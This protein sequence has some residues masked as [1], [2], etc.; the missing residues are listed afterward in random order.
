MSNVDTAKEIYQAFGRGDVPATL[1]HLDENVQWETKVHQ[2][3]VPWLQPRHGKDS[4]PAFFESLASIEIT[5]F[6]PY[7]FFESG[8]KVL[9]LIKFEAKS[10]GNSYSFPL[11]AHLWQFNSAGKVTTYDHITDTAQMWRLANA[12]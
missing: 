9:V 5:R 11:N 12:R 7:E 6:E 4:I 3:G 10:Q 1:E 2:E 8:D